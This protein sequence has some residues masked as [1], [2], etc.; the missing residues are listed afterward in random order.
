MGRM[1]T[2]LAFAALGIAVLVGGAFVAGPSV[3]APGESSNPARLAATPPEAIP[4]AQEIVTLRVDNMW[5][6]SCPYIV[7][8]VLQDV[9]G[10]ISAMVSFRNRSAV[11]TYDSERTD[12]SVLIAATTDYG[13]PSVV[14][15]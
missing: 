2:T 13:F 5:C 7:R 15:R 12:P 6:A 9:P 8:Q 4:A 3:L 1:K 10:V 14:V 11:V